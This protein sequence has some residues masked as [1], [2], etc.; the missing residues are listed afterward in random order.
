[1]RLG[2]IKLSGFKSIADP[3]TFQMPGQRMTL[4]RKDPKFRLTL[5]VVVVT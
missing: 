5:S 1:M 3:T 2:Q 4:R